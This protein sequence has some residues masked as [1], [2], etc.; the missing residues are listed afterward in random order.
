MDQ[1]KVKLG[2]DCFYL[3]TEFHSIDL[4]TKVLLL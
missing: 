2:E 1:L 4:E 3:T